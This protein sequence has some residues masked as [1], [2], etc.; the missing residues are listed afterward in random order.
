PINYEC[1]Y[2]KAKSTYLKLDQQG[3]INSNYLKS[4]LSS[5][6]TAVIINQ[7]SNVNGLQQKLVELDQIIQDYNQEHQTKI[8]LIVDASQSYAKTK[9]SEQA[10][11]IYFF[12]QQKSFA[13]PG[14]S[15]FIKDEVQMQ[16]TGQS[17][18]KKA[19]FL[20]SQIIEAGTPHFISILSIVK[21]K[22]FL[23]ELDQGF[24]LK[25]FDRFA[26][27]ETLKNYA[28]EKLK[29]IPNIRFLG[30]TDQNLSQNLGIITFCIES[31]D[32]AIVAQELKSFG[33]HVE[34]SKM[35]DFGAYFC[36]GNAKNIYP[37][38]YEKQ[39]AMRISI[40]W[41][42]DQDDLDRFFKFFMRYIK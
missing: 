13:L 38:L 32:L 6:T 25:G 15:V 26:Q 29:E 4:Q 18:L 8:L 17:D 11:D 2:H 23:L 42:N 33:I 10:G 19:N 3:F 34:A 28:Y 20:L 40:Q 21:A 7:C 35:D 22:E 24:Y 5:E 30:L 16:L 41:Y 12:A 37:C 31:K 9:I 14:C 27:I 36:V 1:A 39:S